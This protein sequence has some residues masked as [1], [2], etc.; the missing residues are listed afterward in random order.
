MKIPRDLSGDQ[1]V[2]LLEKLGYEPVRRSGSHI[3]LTHPGPPAHSATIPLHKTLKV[4]TINSIVSA[5]SRHLKI[6][7]ADIL[8][9]K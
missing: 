1:L 6:S 3:R 2:K 9:G 7:K 5:V 4:G 8:S